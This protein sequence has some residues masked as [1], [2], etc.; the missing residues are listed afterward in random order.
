MLPHSLIVK[1]ASL[2]PPMH[3]TTHSIL[4]SLV[5]TRSIACCT[6]GYGIVEAMG[7]ARVMGKNSGVYVACSGQRLRH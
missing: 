2:A 1:T 5:T 4:C 3:T 7:A 6:V